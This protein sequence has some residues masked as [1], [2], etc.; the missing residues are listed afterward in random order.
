MNGQLLIFY[1]LLGIV[2]SITLHF[3]IGGSIIFYLIA[4]LVGMLIGYTIRK[5]R[6]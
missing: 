6:K 5:L 1:I 2:I 3:F 4:W